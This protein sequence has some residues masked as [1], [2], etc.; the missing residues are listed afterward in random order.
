MLRRHRAALVSEQ[1]PHMGRRCA[2]LEAPGVSQG[3]SSSSSGRLWPCDKGAGGKTSLPFRGSRWL[4][5]R[6]GTGHG[7]PVTR[8]S[9]CTSQ[10]RP[11]LSPWWHTQAE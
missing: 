1:V 7:A 4:R 10:N 2:E 9:P 3:P 11:G 8:P 5:G 6:G